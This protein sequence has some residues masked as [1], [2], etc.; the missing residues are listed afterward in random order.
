MDLMFKDYSISKL[1][2]GREKL[3]KKVIITASTLVLL[4]GGVSYAVKANADHIPETEKY[5]EPTI[6]QVEN[7][8]DITLDNETYDEIEEFE[9]YEAL[10]NILE[11][12]NAEVVKDNS[13]KRMILLM[14]Q[15]GHPQ[16]KSIYI[17][18]KD[19]LK[20]VDFDGGLV[21]N[22]TLQKPATHH[23]EEK[24]VTH[25]EEE[26]VVVTDQ[27]NVPAEKQ[28]ESLEESATINNHID[29]SNLNMQVV[30]ENSHKR[31]I[32]YKGDHQKPQYKTIFVKKSGY[33]KIIDLNGGLIYNGKI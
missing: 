25:H 3:M 2:K 19:R 5:I 18:K 15:N 26:E 1:K 12:V 10:V 6:E 28:N 16:Y 29:V 31:V 14:D 22:E 4:G 17:K 13:D 32:L 8:Y 30:E 33:L 20:V 7:T 27:E 23:E 9:E 21:F 11:T 24:V